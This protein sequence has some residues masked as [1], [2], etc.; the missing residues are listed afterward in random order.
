MKR[1]LTMLVAVAM[2]AAACGGGSGSGNTDPASAN[3]CEDLA[4]VTI[5]LM[6]DAIDAMEGLELADFLEMS[7]TGEMPE[8]LTQLEDAGA[9]IEQ[10]AE[11]LNCS[12]ED[13]QRLVCERIDSL[14]AE[15]EIAQMIL[16]GV[17]AE[18]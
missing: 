13:A 14:H 10:R 17:A 3:S 8:E 12:A 4:D 1:P 15:G 2:V 9:Q 6:Q 7:D 18:C 5:N 16:E 11:E